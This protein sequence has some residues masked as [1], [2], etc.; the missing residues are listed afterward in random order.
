M[1]FAKAILGERSWIFADF[2]G[3]EVARSKRIILSHRKYVTDMLSGARL[4]GCK[5]ADAPMKVN[6]KLLS[7][8]GEILDDHGMY[9]KLVGKLI[10]NGN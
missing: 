2:L 6:V 8:H 7:D 10:P 9:H 5:I 1:L 3:I 4:L